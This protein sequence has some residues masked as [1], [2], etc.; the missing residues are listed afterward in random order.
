[1]CLVEPWSR[2]QAIGSRKSVIKLHGRTP[3]MNVTQPG[4][5]TQEE[6]AMA[7][8]YDTY[9]TL[10]RSHPRGRPARSVSQI[11]KSV[12]GSTK[13]TSTKWSPTSTSRPSPSGCSWPPGSRA[14]LPQAPDGRDA[15]LRRRLRPA[16]GHGAR[17]GIPDL[18]SWSAREPSRLRR[19]PS[20]GRSRPPRVPHPVSPSCPLSPSTT[21][22]ATPPPAVPQPD[23]TVV[24]DI[25]QLPDNPAQ[26]GPESPK[27]ADPDPEPPVSKLP[28]FKLPTP[29]KPKPPV[30]M[31]DLTLAPNPPAPKPPV[32][33]DPVFSP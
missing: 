19:H 6:P 15:V 7:T 27:P 10:R 22:I 21:N 31:P 30:S 24:I 23:T 25:P 14:P 17:T 3:T 11:P 16:R 33:I 9:P 26:R 5:Q 2:R 20:K 8:S 32:V 12:M 29:P 1:M 18:R 4:P 28:D 13:P